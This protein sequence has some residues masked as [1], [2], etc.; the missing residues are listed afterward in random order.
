MNIVK[1]FDTILERK[2]G[3]SQDEILKAEFERLKKTVKEKKFLT[4]NKYYKWEK[5]YA[6]NLT[7]KMLMT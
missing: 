3:L 1:N 5:K 2:V 6:L 4:I 7:L